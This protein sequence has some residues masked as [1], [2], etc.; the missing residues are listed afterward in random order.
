MYH[1][2]AG[3]FYYPMGGLGDYV[4]SRADLNEAIS[5]AAGV[6]HDWFTIVTED[7]E[8]Q[9]VEVYSSTTG[10]TGLEKSADGG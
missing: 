5:L 6:R 3:D 7:A 8:G 10:R 4:G 9:L 1:A 2:F